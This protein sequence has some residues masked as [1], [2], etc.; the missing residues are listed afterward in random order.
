MLSYE[1]I[2]RLLI[3]LSLRASDEPFMGVAVNYSAKYL[4]WKDDIG[5]DS[6]QMLHLSTLTNT[7]FNL[8]ELEQPPYLL[9]FPK[10]DDW[11]ELIFEA[12]KNTI[13]SLNF[14]TSGTTGQVKTINHPKSFLAREIDFL[15]TLFSDAKQIIPYV[16]SCNIYG[17]LLTVG[18]P[19][20]LNIPVVYPSEINIAKLATHSL[21][22]ATPFHWQFLLQNMPSQSVSTLAVSSSSKLFDGLYQ[23]VENKGIKL[24][25]L[26]G[27]T[28]TTGVGYRKSSEDS[29]TLFPYWDFHQEN[30]SLILKDKEDEALMPLMDNLVQLTAN[31]FNL[32][33][34]KDK[35]INIAGNLTDLDYIAKVIKNIPNV[36]DCALSAKAVN[37]ELMIQAYITL[38]IKDASSETEI[39][40]QIK[41]ALKPHEMPR[42]VVFFSDSD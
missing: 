29:F 17:F 25:E 18:L 16:P 42:S 6:I 30:N 20:K 31:S 33:A 5:L 15:A 27:S 35:K 40:K 37:N 11:V 23:Q 26:Y 41:S 7:F 24:T 1:S 21:I 39:K 3:D 9:Q 8:F 13:K 4:T 10:V 14:F 12:H 22:V 38:I 34:R 36:K 19:H 2:K 32:L 28:E